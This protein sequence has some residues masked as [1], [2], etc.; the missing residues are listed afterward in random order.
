M[1]YTEDSR[2][3]GDD[4]MFDKIRFNENIIP[5]ALTDSLMDAY[6]SG[7]YDHSIVQ[8]GIQIDDNFREAV[9]QAMHGARGLKYYLEGSVKTA[10]IPPISDEVKENLF[11]LETFDIYTHYYPSF[12]RCEYSGH[13]LI[14]LYTYEGIGY[15]KYQGR[16]FELRKGEGIYLYAEYPHEHGCVSS[17]WVYCSAELSGPWISAFYK[18]YIANGSPKFSQ[19]LSGFFQAGMEELLSIYDQSPIYRDWQV[20]ACIIRILTD[21]CVKP[22]DLVRETAA[23]SDDMQRLVKYMEQNF[24]KPLTIDD[25]CRYI[26]FGRA[27]L[28]A[29]FKKYTNIPPI[30]YLIQL[31]LQQACGLLSSTKKSCSEIAAEVG[32]R[33]INNFINLFKKHYGT[34]PLRYRKNHSLLL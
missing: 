28:Q 5:N 10:Y 23:E 8:N 29:E 17:R 7:S 1:L 22:H 4:R 30:E 11:F 18:N 14:L 2:K 31:R 13:R 6:M 15:V 32:F 16:R 12:M 25:L 21:F 27:K 26:G 9:R 34:T 3:D 20:N 33:D 19:D 24:E